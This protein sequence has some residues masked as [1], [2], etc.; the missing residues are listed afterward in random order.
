MELFEQQQKFVKLKADA[1]KKQ[2]EEIQAFEHQKF[3]F[4][5]KQKLE[6]ARYQQLVFS[7]LFYFL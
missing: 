5:Q 4:E 6:A 1:E 3:L 2:L 7:F